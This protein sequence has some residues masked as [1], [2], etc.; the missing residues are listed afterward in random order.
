MSLLEH[1]YDCGDARCD[2]ASGWQSQSL[3]AHCMSLALNLCLTSIESFSLSLTVF[4]C[5][6]CHPSWPMRL[7]IQYDLGWR[8]ERKREEEFNLFVNW[9]SHKIYVK[10]CVALGERVHNGERERETR[11]ASLYLSSLSLLGL[12]PIEQVRSSM[13]VRTILLLDRVDS[14]SDVWMDAQTERYT[15]Y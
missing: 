4:D 5:C 9:C 2:S 1:I 13:Y 3:H 10:V 8:R 15:M 6:R 14:S 7:D 11:L 12:G